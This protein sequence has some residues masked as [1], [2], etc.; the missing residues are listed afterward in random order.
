L[1][2]GIWP[3]AFSP[4][5]RYIP[6]RFTIFCHPERGRAARVEGQ[7]SCICSPR[8]SKPETWNSVLQ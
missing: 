5:F 4:A 7:G 3:L 6:Y 2:F 1:A 8:N